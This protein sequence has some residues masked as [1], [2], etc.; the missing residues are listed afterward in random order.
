MKSISRSVSTKDL[1]HVFEYFEACNPDEDV[2]GLKF[3]ETSFASVQFINSD[4]E[5]KI[6]RQRID[7]VEAIMRFVNEI[8]QKRS[9]DDLLDDFKDADKSRSGVLDRESFSE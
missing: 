5:I 8:V 2:I 9:L 7:L 6:L 3:I 1:T 4:K